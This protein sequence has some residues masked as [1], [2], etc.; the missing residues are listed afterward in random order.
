MHIE[1]NELFDV[2]FI[3]DEPFVE[4]TVHWDKFYQINNVKNGYYLSIKKGETTLLTY[5]REYNNQLKQFQNN[6][7][8]IIDIIE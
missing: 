1:L 3:D 7:K 2:K 6:I 8:A 4:T 5:H